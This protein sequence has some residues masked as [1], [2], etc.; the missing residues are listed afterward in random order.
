MTLRIQSLLLRFEKRWELSDTQSRS[1]AKAVTW[2]LTGTTDTFL[3]AWL[4]TGEPLL[5]SGIAL[6]EVFT[7][8]FLFWG[9]ERIWNHTNWGRNI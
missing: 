5:A 7:K 2:R 1:L 8:V 3:I 6:A 4:F 9:H